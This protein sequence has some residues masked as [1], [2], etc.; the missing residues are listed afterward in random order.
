V[1]FFLQELAQA[2]QSYYT[3][4]RNEGDAILPQASKLSSGWESRW[5]REKTEA[6]LL[7]V[8]A[9]RTVYAAGLG[10]LGISAPERMM[11]PDD[12]SGENADDGREGDTD[13]ALASP[14]KENPR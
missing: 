2:F 11:R 9:I 1:V 5:D 7:W 8:D 12:P 4:L 13:D 10:L 3:R 6:R 14:T